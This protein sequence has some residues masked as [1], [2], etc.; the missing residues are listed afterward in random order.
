MSICKKIKLLYIYSLLCC[1][2]DM[3]LNIKYSVA[4]SNIISLRWQTADRRSFNFSTDASSFLAWFVSDITQWRN[5]FDETRQTPIGAQYLNDFFHTKPRQIYHNL[6]IRHIIVSKQY[7]TEE[8][9]IIIL[10]CPIQYAL[11]LSFISNFETSSRVVFHRF[12]QIVHPKITE[13]QW[14][15]GE[16][17][18][19]IRFTLR[20][21]N[22]L[23][24][25]LVRK[26]TARYVYCAMFEGKKSA[27]IAFFHW[28]MAVNFRQS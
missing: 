22:Y 9:K 19:S 25:L 1:I 27:Y 6:L 13:P 4:E 15:S 23:I 21:N 7:F 18:E 24:Y 11:R 14:F 5:K 12:K 26:W 20:F 2:Y 10:M 28:T 8:L 16:L 17:R 3:F